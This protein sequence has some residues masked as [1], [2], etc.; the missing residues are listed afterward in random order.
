MMWLKSAF[1]N[2]KQLKST[3]YMGSVFSPAVQKTMCDSVVDEIFSMMMD[4]SV[5]DYDKHLLGY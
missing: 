5:D 1:D 4:P 3:N 2:C